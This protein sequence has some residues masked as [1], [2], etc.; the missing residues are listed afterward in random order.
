V[1]HLMKTEQL[2]VDN[3]AYPPNVCKTLPDSI[4]TVASTRGE[5]SQ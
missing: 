2:K 1:I 5:A 4:F 3:R